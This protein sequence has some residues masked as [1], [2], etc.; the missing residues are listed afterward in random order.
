MQT[1]I[2]WQSKL[3]P[4]TFKSLA[5]VFVVHLRRMESPLN[6]KA[7]LDS[8]QVPELQWCW[9]TSQGYLCGFWYTMLQNCGMHL[10]NRSDRG[11]KH[12]LFNTD[13][14]WSTSYLSKVKRSSMSICMSNMMWQRDFKDIS[15]NFP[16]GNYTISI[17]IHEFKYIILH[18]SYSQESPT[19]FAQVHLFQTFCICSH[20]KCRS[21]CQ[22]FIFCTYWFW[23][24]SMMLDN[25]LHDLYHD[26]HF[27][28]A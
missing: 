20:N 5:S 6:L 25:T 3:S 14:T 10:E 11:K 16:A 4:A 1:I 28:T 9:I 22:H 19:T 21:S 8:W 12:Q 2:C 17:R 24:S 27:L 15:W 23:E 18:L 26:V 7:H 13:S